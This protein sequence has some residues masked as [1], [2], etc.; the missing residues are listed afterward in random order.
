MIFALYN[1]TCF[2]SK[3]FMFEVA[4]FAGYSPSQNDLSQKPTHYSGRVR[5]IQLLRACGS[6]FMQH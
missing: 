4:A 6:N 2:K 3:N 1:L 5:A